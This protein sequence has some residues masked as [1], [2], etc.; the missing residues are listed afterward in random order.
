MGLDSR[1]GELSGVCWPGHPVAPRATD[2]IACA[3]G[4]TQVRSSAGQV[5]RKLVHQSIILTYT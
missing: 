3:T 2:K 1:A 4:H 5:R